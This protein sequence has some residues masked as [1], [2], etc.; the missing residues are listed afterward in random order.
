MSALLWIA[1]MSSGLGFAFRLGR[2]LALGRY[3]VRRAPRA[4]W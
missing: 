1:I 3:D 2:M 4:W